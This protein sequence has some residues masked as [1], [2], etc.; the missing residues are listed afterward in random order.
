M[1]Y[2]ETK[3]AE[4][5]DMPGNAIPQLALNYMNYLTQ[6]LGASLEISLTAFAHYNQAI[7]NM[8][9]KDRAYEIDEQGRK[10]FEQ[11]K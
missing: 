7:E 5:L 6:K 10:W 8:S 9:C 4:M 2:A 1:N 11:N 3:A